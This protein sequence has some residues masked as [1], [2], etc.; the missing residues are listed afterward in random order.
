[1]RIITLSYFISTRWLIAIHIHLIDIDFLLTICSCMK[2]VENPFA[3]GEK[4]EKA[5]KQPAFFRE[6]TFSITFSVSFLSYC[7]SLVRHYIVDKEKDATW[8]YNI[9]PSCYLTKSLSFSISPILLLL[10][11]SFS[12]SPSFLYV[13]LVW[14]DQPFQHLH[15]SCSNVQ[16]HHFFSL[17]TRKT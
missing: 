16:H 17:S 2:M 9:L 3:N 15:C 10:L 1:M 14:L 8:Q 12:S 5:W 4:R 6:E 7:F 11:Y 13:S